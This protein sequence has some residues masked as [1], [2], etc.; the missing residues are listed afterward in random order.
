LNKLAIL[1]DFENLQ[2]D[3]ELIKI[4]YEVSESHYMR[5][6]HKVFIVNLKI[7]TLSSDFVEAIKGCPNKDLFVIFDKNYKNNIV[8]HVRPDQFLN[9]FG[10]TRK[11]SPVYNLSNEQVCFDF[12]L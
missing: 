10:G 12:T 8:K 6:I 2:A 1:I 4:L 7:E 3:P 11:Y 9:M 5:C